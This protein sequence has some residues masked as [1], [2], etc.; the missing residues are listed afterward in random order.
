M[1]TGSLWL[2]FAMILVH[3]DNV[4]MAAIAA[5]MA[6]AHIIRDRKPDQ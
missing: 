5:I 6:H 1:I 3:T 4:V 2:I